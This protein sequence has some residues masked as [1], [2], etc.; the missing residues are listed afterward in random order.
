MAPKIFLTGATGYIGGDALYSLVKAHPD[1]EYTLL[2]RNE[3]RGKPVAAAYPN[4]R[5][6]YGS[7]DDVDVIEK[8]AAA[9]DIVIHTADSADNIPSAKAIAKGLA[10]GHTAEKPG[11][12][13]HLCGTGILTWYDAAHERYGQ[14]PIPE[15]KYHDI[16]DVERIVSLPD[17][18]IHR[19]VDKVVLGANDSPAVRTLIVGPPTIYGRG[20]GPT[21]QRSIQVPGIVDFTLKNG[22]APIQAPGLTE[23]DNVHI[24]DLGD[25]FVLAVDAA[26]DPAKSRNPEIFGPRAYFFL[27][28]GT[29]RWSDV[30]KWVAA[31][32]A[33]QGLIPEP[34]AKEIDI[35]RLGT[36]SKSVAARAGKYLGWAAKSPSLKETIPDVVASEAKKLGKT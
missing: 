19:D 7:L 8:E 31:E 32:A 30:S 3:E 2:V 15:Q 33:K 36:N 28:N 26:L 35:P 25:F 24:H 13:I 18:A 14:A 5:L 6:V 27:E 23:W 34:I 1:Y 29:H 12:W 4:A 21:N 20:R 17:T 16:D 9:A 10:A 22:F 11:Y